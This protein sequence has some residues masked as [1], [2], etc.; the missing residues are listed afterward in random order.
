MGLTQQANDDAIAALRIANSTLAKAE[1]D[2]NAANQLVASIRS[3][4]DAA[5]N[6]YNSAEWAWEQAIN[7][8]YVAQAQ[9]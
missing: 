2:L 9:K 6:E 1:V 5:Q 4:R 7:A 8:L 3:S